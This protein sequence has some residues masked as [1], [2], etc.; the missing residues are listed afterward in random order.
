MEQHVHM[1][2]LIAVVSAQHYQQ[3]DQALS[4]RL[5]LEFGKARWS[6]DTLRG[7]VE[8]VFWQ[9]SKAVD[10]HLDGQLIMSF[11]VENHIQE[12]TPKLCYEYY[13]IP[14]KEIVHGD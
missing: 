4:A 11:W 9:S 8:Y 1:N 5:N 10:V 12:Y 6:I 13:N 7:R 2:D 14:P 3:V